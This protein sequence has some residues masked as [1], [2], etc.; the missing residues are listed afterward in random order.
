MHTGRWVHQLDIPRQRV[1]AGAMGHSHAHAT[2]LRAQL[3][4]DCA[5]RT[6]THVC[7]LTMFR[8]V[9]GITTV[10]SFVAGALVWLRLRHRISA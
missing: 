9:I 7:S 5:P 6:T 3:V 10:V 1:R 4:A 2:V 8:L